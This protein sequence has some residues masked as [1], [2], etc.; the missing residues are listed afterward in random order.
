MGVGTSVQPESAPPSRVGS[1]PPMPLSPSSTTS[2]VQKGCTSPPSE[3]RSSITAISPFN[4]P[5]TWRPEIMQVILEK[6]EEEQKRMLTPSVRNSIVRDL[7]T[8][9]Y[10]Y[11]PKPDAKFCTH[12]AQQLVMKYTFMRD[13]GGNRYVSC[14]LINCVKAYRYFHCEGVKEC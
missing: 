9:M 13:A 8:T 5:D 1:P 11:M 14:N 6:N 7:V 4:I 3:G 12:V 2:T 10:T